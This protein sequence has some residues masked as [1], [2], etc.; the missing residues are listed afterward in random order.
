[1]ATSH[2]AK[3]PLD[4]CHLVSFSLLKAPLPII[5]NIIMT[6]LPDALLAHVASYL[7]PNTF[8]TGL[9]S[10]EPSPPCF[11]TTKLNQYNMLVSYLK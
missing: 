4:K 9:A 6:N 7:S 1:M 10:V 3:T 2:P 11:S 5:I 8:A